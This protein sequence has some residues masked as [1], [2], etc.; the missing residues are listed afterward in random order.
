MNKQAPAPR[1]RHSCQ[2]QSILAL[3]Q[4][5]TAHPTAAVIY[6]GLRRRLPKLSL[7]TV[8]RN[9]EILRAQGLVRVLGGNGRETRYDARLVPHAHFCCRECGRVSDLAVSGALEKALPALARPAGRV[10][11]IRLELTGT[12]HRCQRSSTSQEGTRP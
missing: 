10:E 3:L 7:G 4:G 1:F 11:D 2:R 5:T 6:A 8:Y 12:C 9:L